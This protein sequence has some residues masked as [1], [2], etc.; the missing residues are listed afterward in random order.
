MSIVKHSERTVRSGCQKCG[1]TD[2]YW[3]HDT[4]ITTGN[5]PMANSTCERCKV[6]GGLVLG[7]R[8]GELHQCSGRKTNIGSTEDPIIIIDDPGRGVT[9]PTEEPGTANVAVRDNDGLKAIADMIQ[10]YLN[11]TTGLKAEIESLVAAAWAKRSMPTIVEVKYD[12]G[13][14]KKIEG[15]THK[16]LPEVLQVLAARCHVMMVGPAG[17]GKSTLAEQAAEALELSY[18]SISLSP[19]TPASA[20]L[21]YM[22]ATGQY[23]PS[24]FRMWYEYGG[25]FH[26]DE[27]DNAHPSILATVNAALANG[28]MAF[29]DG[30]VKRHDSSR[31]AGSA[32]TFGRG[33]DRQYVGRSPIDGATLDRFFVIVVEYDNALEDALAVAT[34][35]DA[36][37][38][39]VEIVRGLRKNAVS[40][41]MNVIVSPRASID[42]CKVMAA[43]GS[44][45]LCKE[46]RLRRGLSDADWRKLSDGVKVS[47]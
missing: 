41:N 19:Q 30:M 16:C 43:G 5:R 15:S 9:P 34:G 22:N 37:S 38:A 26:F 12:D 27:M 11:D 3:Y 32:N 13:S 46:G 45:S 40:Q 28:Q 18:F 23:V 44:W 17:T 20:L 21:G 25:I 24:L 33:A 7:T 2:L 8:T 39:V 10:P 36:W 1:N 47:L 14:L 35:Y 6:R 4:D 42:I 31:A 29:P